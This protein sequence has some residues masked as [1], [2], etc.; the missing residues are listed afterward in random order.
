MSYECFE[1]LMDTLKKYWEH[2]CELERSLGVQ[3]EENWMTDHF[4][5]ICEAITTEFEGPNPEDIDPKIGPI[6]MYYIF[7]M[8]FGEEKTIM[9]YKGTNYEIKHLKD[10]YRTLNIIKYNKDHEE[11]HKEVKNTDKDFLEERYIQ[12][13]GS[14]DIA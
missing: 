9:P 3:F 11:E 8:D 1:Q 5:T 13:G 12:I 7:D 6:I 10:L 14:I 4:D 2:M